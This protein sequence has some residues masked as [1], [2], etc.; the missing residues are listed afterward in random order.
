M[1]QERKSREYSTKNQD[2]DLSSIYA[3]MPSEDFIQVDS[4]GIYQHHSDFW[5]AQMNQAAQ[6][7]STK[8]E[9]VEEQVE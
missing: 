9:K 3:D 7:L 6:K 4:Q 2:V 1:A 8:M 5:E